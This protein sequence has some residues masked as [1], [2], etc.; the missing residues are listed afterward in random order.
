MND[1]A[2]SAPGASLVPDS[3]GLITGVHL[4][5]IAILALLAL[6]VIVWGARLKHRRRQADRELHAHNRDV[7][8]PASPSPPVAVEAPVA[9][10]PP[11]PPPVVEPDPV[12]APEPLAD[13]PIAATAPLQDNP[14]AVAAPT[15]PVFADRVD[16]ADGPVTQLKGLGPKVAG[17]LAELGVTNVGQLAALDADAAT[18]L[19]VQLGSFSGRMARDRWIEQARFLAA[20]DQAGFEAVFG[21]L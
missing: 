14:A 9:V 6:A 5:L 19:D 8:A 12:P 11:P 1:T 7:A 16:P 10:A 21:K 13:E 20:G 4:G 3:T 2:T 15:A 18:R 17:R